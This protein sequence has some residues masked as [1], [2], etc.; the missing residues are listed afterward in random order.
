MNPAPKYTRPAL[1]YRGDQIY[2]EAVV[3]DGTDRIESRDVAIGI[4]DGDR[5]EVLEGLSEGDE[6]RVQ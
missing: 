4:V 2:V 6:V 3:R 5:V 1:R